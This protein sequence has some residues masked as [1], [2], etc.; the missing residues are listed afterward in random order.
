MNDHSNT[1]HLHI[2]IILCKHQAKEHPLSLAGH[3]HK[4]IPVH[5]Y[6][7]TTFADKYVGF[8]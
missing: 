8:C 2:G 3:I 5:W 1:I 6:Q 7:V 4:M